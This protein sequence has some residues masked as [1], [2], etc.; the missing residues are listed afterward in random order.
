M[1]A[2]DITAQDYDTDRAKLIPCFERLYQTALELIPQGAD[3]ILD[4]GAGTGLLTAFVRSRFSDARLH[5]IDSSQPMLA[6]AERRFSGDGEILCQL[7]DYTSAR[8]SS[9]YDT[10]VS[11]LSIH[12][13]TDEAKRGLF[14]RVRGVLKT[15]GVF[16]NLEQILQKTPE[17]EAQAKARWLRDVRTLGATERQIEASLLR[18]TQDRCATADDQLRWLQ[19]AGFCE[20][21]CVF[22]EGRFAVLFAT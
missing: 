1:D 21:R 19:E 18:Q 20:T 11:A 13:L 10:V 17:L 7:G 6:Q 5:L 2:F 16:V 12:H 3:Y 4:L 8:W 9:S 22:A 15:G 14:A